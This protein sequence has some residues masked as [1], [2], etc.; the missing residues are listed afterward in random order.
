VII[1][2]KKNCER[3]V[4]KSREA[5]A[6]RKKNCRETKSAPLEGDLKPSDKLGKKPS[7]QPVPWG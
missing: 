2:L 6:R 7:T 3:G 4:R 5:L 1:N